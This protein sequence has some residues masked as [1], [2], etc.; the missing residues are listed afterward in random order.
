VYKIK[1]VISIELL[2]L[3]QLQRK[4]LTVSSQVLIGG[5][6]NFSFITG[7]QEIA[8]VS[9]NQEWLGSR[10]IMVPYSSFWWGFIW[11]AMQ[12]VSKSWMQF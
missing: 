11:K 2:I 1:I 7:L 8:E 5:L 4:K 3:L 10:F 6:P 12:S 9:W